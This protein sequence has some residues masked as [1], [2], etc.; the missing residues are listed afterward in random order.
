MVSV[1]WV[2]FNW[3][4]AE[5]LLFLL[6]FRLVSTLQPEQLQKKIMTTNRILAAGAAVTVLRD[7]PRRS[8]G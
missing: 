1:S 3:L 8:K 5:I 2:F 7:K 6:F 4:C